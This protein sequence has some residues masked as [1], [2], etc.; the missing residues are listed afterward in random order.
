MPPP[1]VLQPLTL[2]P[3][4]RSSL[5]ALPSA[6][7]AR[8][9]ALRDLR[10]SGAA[11][12][13]LLV[14]AVTEPKQR[15]VARLYHPGIRPKSEVLRWISAEAPRYVAQLLDCG[16]SDG[17][18]YELL[19]YAEQ[20]SLRELMAGGALAEVETRELLTELSGALAELHQRHIPHGDLKPENVL[21]RRRQPLQLALTNFS[22]ASLAEALPGFTTSH[23]AQYAA[24]ETAT[25]TAGM[26]ADYWSLGMILLEALTGRH[27]FA[28]LSGMV[29]RYQLRVRPAPVADVVEPWRTLC[30]GLLLRDPQQRWGAAEVRRWL[31]GESEARPPADAPQPEAVTFRPGRFY[32]LAGVD[33]R[34]ARELAAQ[35][36]CH[37]EEASKALAQGAIGDWLRD[38][39]EHEIGRAALEVLQADDM[40]PDERLTRLLAHLGADLPPRWKQWSLSANDL[41]ITAQAARDGDAASQ[42]LLLQLHQGQPDVLGIYA[43][44]GNAEC[45][46]MQAAWRA[47]AADYQRAWQTALAYRLPVKA[48]PDWAAALPDLLLAVVSPAFQSQLQAEAQSLAQGM[49]PRPAWVDIL[50]SS[51]SPGAALALRTILRWLPIIVEIQRHT[52]PRL[53]ALLQEF[54]ILHR[55]PDFRD[56]LDRFDQNLCSGV[57]DSPSAAAQALD[58]LHEDAQILA[59]VLRQ[60]YALSE[61]TAMNSAASPALR[62]W[63]SRLAAP[64]YAD[65]EFLRRELTQPLR[66]RISVDGWERPAA[67]PLLWEHESVRWSGAPS[68]TIVVAF[69]PDGQWLASGGGDQ[70]VRLW[71]VDA[72][73]CVATFHGHSRSISAIAFS[74]D[75][76]WLASSGD[77]TVRLW[78]VNS[79]QCLATLRGHAGIVSAVAFSPNGRWLASGS[80]DRSVRLWR[81]D[82]RQ[83]ATIL[84]GHTG[85]V[86][87]VAFGPDGQSL[88]SGGADRSVRLWRIENGQCIA[89]LPGRTGRVTSVAFSP[90]GRWLASGSGSF[91]ERRRDDDTVRLWR[92]ENRQCV[93]AFPG[94]TASVNTVA[95]SP[96]GRWLASGSADG[97]VR[98][99][100]VEN[101]QCAAILA[102]RAGR[103]T[104]VAFSPDGRRLASGC[105]NGLV[106]WDSRQTTIVQ[107]AIEEL[108]AWEKARA[109]Q[110]SDI[111]R[112]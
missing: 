28:G 65:A 49:N 14:E 44:A 68:G 53:E 25:G 37:W 90:D 56:A 1:L 21:V 38:L 110:Y 13:L 47:A 70:A 59:D 67:S 108:I 63:Q 98:L 64:R 99:W 51:A 40:N 112:V 34:T 73:Q 104:G 77:R 15:A 6:L 24:P 93:A 20:G 29:I 86:N 81:M 23:S 85:A 26:A 55:S 42:A 78:R 100:R 79:G 31:A 45:Q 52:A 50:S 16:Y 89:T 35:M 71:R 19:E 3:V 18:A 103:V 39:G 95:F 5:R 2:P 97:A 32:R 62:Q 109:G 11:T 4:E 61:Q 91:S 72:Q 83:C 74:P 94:H 102:E 92:V 107:M 82:G 41:A 27:P 10:P 7:A 57:Y 58:A 33:C 69:S 111:Q 60:Y 80:A 17:V 88:A 84:Q 43:A 66:W 36:A 101:R 46:W 96:D 48:Q 30:R 8:Y 76:Q 54:A 22:I 87:A 75:G 12:D 9:R 105:E 106:L